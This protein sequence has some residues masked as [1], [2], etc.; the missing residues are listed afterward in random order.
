M[1]KEQSCGDDKSRK[2]RLSSNLGSDEESKKR[3]F[4]IAA[5]SSDES[6]T[7]IKQ[8]HSRAVSAVRA[9]MM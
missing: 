3:R 6:S 9:L 7:V 8:D 2:R 5:N 1:D 4:S